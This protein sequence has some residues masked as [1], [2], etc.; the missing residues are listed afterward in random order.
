MTGEIAETMSHGSMGNPILCLLATSE[1]GR[2]NII[3]YL[4]K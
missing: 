4:F 1:R 3:V 2:D